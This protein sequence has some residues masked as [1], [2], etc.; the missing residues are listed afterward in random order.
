MESNHAILEGARRRLVFGS[1]FLNFL[2]I[3]W[4]A[5]SLVA[6]RSAPSL[7]QGSDPAS[8]PTSPSQAASSTT[9]L[10][11]D[12]P[13]F[14]P[15]IRWSEI[16]SS[17][18]LQ[19][20]ANLRAIGCPELLVRDIIT[21]DLTDTFSK[22]ARAIWSP[23]HKAYWEKPA[24][25]DRPNPRQLAQLQALAREQAE[26]SRRILGVS[27]RQQE[28]ID[29][30]GLQLWGPSRQLAGLSE[31]RRQAASEALAASGYFEE[32][33]ALNINPSGSNRA[34]RESALE[35][36]RLKALSGILTPEELQEQR[37]RNSSEAAGAR[38]MLGRFEA[39][40][41]EFQALMS[42]NERL[43]ADRNANSGDPYRRK[44]AEVEQVRSVLGE[45]RAAEFEKSSDLFYVWASMAAERYGLPESSVSEAWQ[46]KH[47]A[48]TRAA[49]LQH[50]PGITADVLAEQMK[51]LQRSA[52]ERIDSAL[53][54]DA[55][56][57]A[58]AG[59]GAWLQTLAG[60]RLP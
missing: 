32:L 11:I 35:R 1:V 10:T 39:T 52:Q 8:S 20:V 22:R 53:G 13:A 43:S 60:G 4:I 30:V 3:A 24:S 5:W 59:D 25:G 9:S 15:P 45:A 57:F 27:M 50:Q 51:A 33:E 21:A 16:E 42:V 23:V 56:R 48:L 40:E 28:L 31:A 55:S 49:E 6:A 54:P 36:K 19:Y 37:Y 2:L 7:L 34:Q 26:T 18:Y 14:E 12:A 41:S 58:R 46:A 17:D 44:A 29:L 38:Q 47:D